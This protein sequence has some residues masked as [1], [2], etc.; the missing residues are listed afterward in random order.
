M[1]LRKLVAKALV[2]TTL[3]SFTLSGLS[4]LSLFIFARLLSPEDFGVAAISLAI[5]QLLTVPVEL[6]FHDALVQRKE[7]E[8]IH[9]DSAF[10]CSVGLGIALCVACWA[11]AGFVEQILGTQ[12]LA[13]VLRWMSLSLPGMGFGCVLVAVQRRKLQFRAVALRSLIGR[14]GSAAVAI[15]L[16]FMGYGVWSLVAQQ[17]LLV[18]LGTLSLWVLADERPKFHF[19]WPPAKSLLGFGVFSAGYQLLALAIQR[20]FMVMVGGYLGSAAAGLL[21]VA[22]RGA[23]MLRDLLCTAVYQVAMPLFSRLSDDRE[24]LFVAYNRAVQLTTFLT[25]PVF[26]GLAVCADDAVTIAFGADWIAAA[27]YFAIVS[28]LGPLFFTRMYSVT[29][30]R[31]VGK[32]AAP[33]IEVVV[34]TL[35]AAVFMVVFGKYSIM[36]AMGAWSARLLFSGPVDMWLTRK[37]SG[38]PYLRQL[39]GAG[40]PFVASVVMACAVLA[41]KTY[42]LASAPALVRVAPLAVVGAATYLATIA[43]L[44]RDLIKQFMELITQS[45]PSRG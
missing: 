25:F 36:Y 7:L 18:C 5:I 19:S 38:M 16:A 10:T 12:G 34:Q 42:V 9:V 39:R 31:A 11:C 45:L 37:A 15:T 20:V 24:S 41:L 21:S 29:L 14:A 33:A 13:E 3:E 23:D 17:V 30:L 2:W 44:N 22:F 35:A 26:V 1:S 32:P 8:P 28:L 43:L 27:P 6:L 4:L 40:A